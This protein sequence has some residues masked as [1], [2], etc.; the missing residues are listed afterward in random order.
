MM[1]FVPGLGLIV[2]GGFKQFRR[3]VVMLNSE[4]DILLMESPELKKRPFGEFMQAVC[5]DRGE[6]DFPG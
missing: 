3:P 6:A 2:R 5:A 4:D 1:N